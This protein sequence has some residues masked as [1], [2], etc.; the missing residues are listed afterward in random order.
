LC[1]IRKYSCATKHFLYTIQSA[2]LHLAITA[3][4]SRIDRKISFCLS[5]G[6]L[7]VQQKV[8]LQVVGMT[9]LL[10]AV[11]GGNVKA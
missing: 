9:A 8:H 7:D 6:C 2:F 11:K 4:E 1:Q 5:A 3:D 10:H